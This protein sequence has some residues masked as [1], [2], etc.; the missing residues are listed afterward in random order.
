MSLERGPGLGGPCAAGERMAEAWNDGTA[1][2]ARLSGVA[3]ALAA[4]AIAAHPVGRA[5][6][7]APAP[8]PAAAEAA[9]CTVTAM[10]VNPCRPWSGAVAGTTR[11]PARGRTRSWPTSSASAARSTSST[12]TTRSAR[13]RPRLR[14]AL[15]RRARLD[16]LPQ[17]E[18][19]ERLGG[20][21]N[22]VNAT[23][24]AQIDKMAAQLKSVAPRKIMLSLFGEPERFV[25][26]GTST[27]PGSEGNVGL[28]RR[29][30][31]DVGRSS[32]TASRRSASR[33]SSG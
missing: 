18:A 21:P 1:R 28:A 22:G 24:N 31:G 19:G 20:T 12:G 11:A 13:S 8:P 32:R 26:P 3:L 4:V 33:T 9:D 7:D 30:Q 15:L 27:C 6:L 23:V 14:G 2:R 29:L 16:P 10:L 25:T 5:A 17:L